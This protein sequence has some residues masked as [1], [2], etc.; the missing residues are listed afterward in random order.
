MAGA[1]ETLHMTRLVRP[2]G[3]P[4]RAG[5]LPRDERF[6]DDG[7]GSD[8][9]SPVRGEPGRSAEPVGTGGEP[10]AI[11]IVEDDQALYD[12]IAL[13]LRDAFLVRQATTA[14]EVLQILDRDP[15]ALVM[16]DHR[17]PD[18]TGFEVLASI[19]A[20]HPDV[21]VIMLTGYGSEQLCRAAFKLG[22]AD[23]LPKPFHLFELEGSIRRALAPGS[24]DPASPEPATGAVDPRVQKAALLVQHRYWDRL[25]L[26]R[27]AHDVGISAHRLS[28][29]FH[30]VMGVSFRAYL[31]RVRLERAKRMLSQGTASITEVA[32]AVGFGDLPRFDK[33]FKRDT[34]VTPSTYRSEGLETRT[35]IAASGMPEPSARSRSKTGLRSEA[36]TDESPGRHAR[37]A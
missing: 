27:L 17:L 9:S 28:R 24:A 13:V 5:R 35:R 4:R 32:Q 8:R 10:R 2:S 29:R 11:L 7:A 6:P 22:V 20:L 21:P 37:S 14:G 3:Q 23:Y 34:G 30:E 1:E 18:G 15:I 36:G 25:S 33:L 19:R 16:L 12:V 31:L 26:R